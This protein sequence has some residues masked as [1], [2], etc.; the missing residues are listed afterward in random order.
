MTC[1]VCPLKLTPEVY[2]LANKACGS[3]QRHIRQMLAGFR[4]ILTEPR[5]KPAKWDN[6]ATYNE[7]LAKLDPHDADIVKINKKDDYVTQR[8]D[9]RDMRRVVGLPKFAQLEDQVFTAWV[10]EGAKDE[11]MQEV[12]GLTYSQLVHVKRVVRNRLQKQ[13]GYYHQVK[14]L[15]KEGKTDGR[16]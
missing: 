5:Q 4:G 7:W 1:P 14:K 3:C 11:R 6:S 2:H 15:E 16:I 12:L 10:L 9:L 13:M 8:C